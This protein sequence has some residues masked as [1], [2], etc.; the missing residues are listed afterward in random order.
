MGTREE[1]KEPSSKGRRM[2]KAFCIV[3]VGLLSL[4]I[5]FL[6]AAFFAPKMAKG[7]VTAHAKEWL[8]RRVE[9]GDISFNPFRFSVSV[10]DF[11][12]F[13]GDDETQFVSFR[14][15]FVNAD[16]LCLFKGDI[17]LSEVRLDSPEARIVK[18][19]G[20]FNFSD[21]L[22]RFSSTDSAA[23]EADSSA[24]FDAAAADSSVSAP[25]SAFA[26]PFGISVRN[27]SVLSGNV[28]F[29]D[30]SVNSHIDI[31]DFSVK[32]PEVYFSN[33]NTSAGVHL[34]FAGGGSLDVDADYNMQKGDFRVGV[35]LEK[36]SLATVKPY[37]ESSLNFRDLT[38]FATVRLDLSG[39]VSDVLAST[40]SGTV[41][42]DDVVL[43]ETS[44]KAFKV[45]HVGVGLAS[46]N[47]EENR[48]AVDSVTVRDADLHFDLNKN[49]NNLSVL[50]S[51]RT[52]GA[53]DVAD[54]ASG[55]VVR[56]DSVSDEKALPDSAAPGK[57][58][59]ASVGRLSVSGVKFTLNDNTVPG[60]FSYVVSG[61]SVAASDVA[62]DNRTNVGVEASLP[63]GG[64]F[65]L[66]AVFN[67]SDLNSFKANVS[68]KNVDMRDFSKYAEHYTGYPLTAGRLAFASDNVLQNGEIDSRNSI[69]IYDLTVGDKPDGAKPEFNVPMKVALYILKDKD[70]KIAFDVPVKGNVRDPEFSYGKIIWQTV[71]N[72]MV[73]V[74]L[75]PAKLLLGSSTPSEFAV[76]VAADDL[77]SE[78]YDLA[79]KWTEVLTS[80]PGA[81]LSVVQVFHPKRQLDTLARALKKLDYYKASTGKSALSPVDRK[82]ALEAEPDS[83]FEAFSATWTHP[84]DAELL[85]TLRS[86]S[87]VRNEK[88]LKF[89]QAQPG[90]NRKN[91]KVRSATAAERA[92][93]GKKVTFRMSVELP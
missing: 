4:W 72:L 19:G 68:V 24:A 73:K 50:L 43:T 17:C 65:R 1:M 36:F 32:V 60:K 9:I 84:S 75:S 49:S 69:D 80:R 40:V 78:Q 87:D 8:G 66:T 82:A 41:S 61:I 31:R 56:A 70:G 48:F 92:S 59:Q 64:S 45:S 2:R 14:E 51:P 57:K 28:V 11:R 20:L 71:M 37:L 38:G 21:I 6:V 39:N 79:R 42:V 35:D 27:F 81:T 83:A 15:F 74:A 63:H 86:L 88:L 54:S 85:E 13:E 7:Y 29:D 22:S 47:L 10:R 25:D 55:A 53:V 34:D 33:R 62:L 77:T 18:D 5:L 44:G 93:A 23:V 16:P 58:L 12:L 91:L 67:P 52:S 46:A 3:G 30:K 90:V 89:L 26:L 76:G